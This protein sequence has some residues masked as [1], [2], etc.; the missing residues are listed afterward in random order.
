M[1]VHY[2]GSKERLLTEALAVIRT[3]QVEHV[4]R[5]GLSPVS[6]QEAAGPMRHSSFEKAFRAGWDT[7][8]SPEYRRYL[9]LSYEMLALA[10][11]EPRQ[12]RAFLE[13]TTE[14]WRS[15]FAH[16]L[17][18][19]GFSAGDSS[20][21]TTVYMAALRGLL[22]DLAV[23]GDTDRVESAVTLVAEKLRQDLGRLV[24]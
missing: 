14:E 10:F 23:T 6:A 22:V 24:E 8:A 17:E 21:L 4:M 2:F 13:Q 11:R 16:I 12:Y 15:G 18:G 9:Y 20:T 19:L 1:L 3:R 5:A 7:L